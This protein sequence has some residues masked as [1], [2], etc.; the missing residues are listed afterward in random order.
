M[1]RF[2]LTIMFL[3]TFTRVCWCGCASCKKFSFE[4]KSK[5]WKNIFN[6]IKRL[7]SVALR[8]IKSKTLSLF[9]FAH[10][11]APRHDLSTLFHNNISLLAG[12]NLSTL[13]LKH[14]TSTDIK[15]CIIITLEK[16]HR[17][18]EQRRRSEEKSRISI[19]VPGVA[20]CVEMKRTLGTE[21]W[22]ASCC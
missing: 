21:T 4:W 3:Y 10:F 18:Y 11:T 5:L 19:F 14:Q 6:N 16:I 13:Q 7:N 12:E 15:A 8:R 22:K 17:A 2:T 20:V 9:Y 1:R